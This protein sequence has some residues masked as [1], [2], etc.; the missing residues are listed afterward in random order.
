MAAYRPQAK[1]VTVLAVISGLILIV[2][3]KFRPSASPETPIT[4]SELRRLQFTAQQRSLDDVTSF[5]SRLADQVKPGLV[6]VRG[7]EAGGVVWDDQGTIVTSAPRKPFR[8]T[9]TAGRFT[10]EQ[11]VASLHFPVGAFRAP[12]EAGLETYFRG[13]ADTLKQGS[14]ILK[15]TAKRDGGHLYAPGTYEGV[16]AAGCSGYTVQTVE[17]N[18]PLDESSAGGAVFDLEGN[19]LG[20]IL[21]CDEGHSAVTPE[22]VDRMLEEARSLSGQILRRYGLHA[23]PLSDDLREYFVID[24]GLI[25]NEIWCNWP[26]DRAGIV[27]GDII[28]SLDEGEVTTPED[29]RK[30]LLPVAFPNFEVGLWRGGRKMTLTLPVS[31]GEL[32]MGS[33]AEGPGILLSAGPEGYPIDEIT[34]GSRADRAELARGDRLLRIGGQRP[35]SLDAARK[36][37]SEGEREPVYVVIQRGQKKLGA[38]LR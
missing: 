12:N 33:E 23:E 11:D 19:L 30:L 18:L 17:T 38:Y 1:Y 13:R 22:G 14:W 10:L 6:W 26:A 7:L 2:G 28:V 20:L 31:R 24:T 8:R 5:F 29:L 15:V 3:A 37:L 32:P 35:R 34:P 27:P 4:Q 21:R 36:V 9:P 16:V 25:V